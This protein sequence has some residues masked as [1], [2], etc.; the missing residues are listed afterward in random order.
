MAILE[1]AWFQVSG[2]RF[3]GNVGFLIGGEGVLIELLQ[4]LAE[5][6]AALG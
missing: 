5:V 2:F 4:A 3:L 6:M 1:G